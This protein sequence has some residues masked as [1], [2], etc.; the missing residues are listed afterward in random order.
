MTAGLGT[1]LV[2][3]ADPDLDQSTLPKGLWSVNIVSFRGQTWGIP[4]NI[5]AWGLPSTDDSFEVST[6][7]GYV[8]T[9]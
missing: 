7:A 6:Q 9:K 2:D 4:N 8:L 5:A 3:L 1:S